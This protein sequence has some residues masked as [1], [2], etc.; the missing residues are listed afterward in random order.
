MEKIW[1]KHYPKKVPAEINLQSYSSVVDVFEKSCAKF[2]GKPAFACMGTVLSYADLDR[3]SRQFATYLQEV[4][5]LKKGDRVALQMPNC[6]QYP[7]ALFGVLRAGCVVV[8]TNPMYTPREME[9]QFKDAGVKAVVIMA[10][11]ASVL[12]EVLPHV[13]SIETVIVTEIGDLL[14][15]PKNYVVNAAVKYV[16]KMVPA[17]NIPQ[18]IG[19]REALRLGAARTFRRPDLSGDDLAFLQYTGGT[20]GVAKGAMLS[21]RNIVA[22]MLQVFA[23]ITPFL[24]ESEEIAIAP[25]PMY[26]IFSLTVNGLALFSFGVCNVLIPNPR[27]MAGFIKELQKYKFTIMVGINTLFNGLLNNKDFVRLDFSRLKASV[28]GGMAVQRAVAERWAK[29]TGK[30]LLEGYGLTET[31]PVLAVNPLDGTE[32]IG[33]IG[34]PVPS[35][36]IRIEKEDGTEAAIGER[37]EICARGPQ[38]MV[39]YWKRQDETDKIIRNGW[40]H[41]GDV[42]ILAEDGFIRIVDRIKDMILVSGFNVYPNEI[43]DVIAKHPG[44]LEVAAVGVNDAKSGEAVKVF[45]VPKDPELTVEAVQ[46][47]CKDQFTGY[48]RPKYVEFRKELPKSNVGKILRRVL[49]DEAANG[50]RLGQ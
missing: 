37:G 39:G 7:V 12:Q 44:V 30:P 26:H 4:V 22:N 38:V 24:N 23:W 27:D 41:T 9:H 48:K 49:R 34:L 36:D 13:P 1:L 5:G 47:F 20:T 6:H 40:L 50:S 28:G 35:T 17:Y 14:D 15:F 2:L 19:F 11:F 45:I 42:G 3:L 25:L 32:Q 29:V 31:S 8:N 18:A 16:K 33:T 46:Q 43:E 10:N 21:H